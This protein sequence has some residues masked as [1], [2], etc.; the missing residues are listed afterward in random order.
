MARSP[1][2]PFASN[3]GGSG[4]AQ[5]TPKRGKGGSPL[6]QLPLLSKGGKSAP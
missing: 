1:S 5:P 3:S 6:E 4:L 2:G